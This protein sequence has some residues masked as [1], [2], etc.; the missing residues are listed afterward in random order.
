MIAVVDYGMG[1]LRR[2]EKALERV[3]CDV[4][5]TRNPKKILASHG[6]V[7]PGV[8]SFRDC[9]SNLEKYELIDC[10]YRFI[11]SGRPYL[12]ICLGLQILF[13]DSDEFGTRKGLGLLKGRVRRFSLLGDLKVPHM[14]WNTVR[15]RKE[16]SVISAIRNGSY[17]YFV[18]SYY[19]L[20]EDSDVIATTTEY[21]I[22]FVSSIAKENILGCQFHP[23]KS[24]ELGLE[25]LKGFG[26]L[27]RK[28]C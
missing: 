13:T 19:V 18:H 26:E 9:M 5:V 28:E 21:G 22:E 7:L 8:G 14:G 6:L 2:V 12:G 11:E 10:L 4:V 27:S 23:E 20:P 16:A 1:N 25:F 15:K 24:Q 17:F 3:G